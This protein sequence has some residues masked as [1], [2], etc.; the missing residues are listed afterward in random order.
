[1]GDQPAEVLC[2]GRGDPD[3]LSWDNSNNNSRAWKVSMKMRVYTW[4]EEYKVEINFAKN[5]FLISHVVKTIGD[6]SDA[7]E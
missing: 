2:P 7:A 3:H 6:A 1:M 4:E 5:G